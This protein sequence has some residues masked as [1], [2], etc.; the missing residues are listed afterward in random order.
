MITL[1]DISKKVGV[2][3]LFDNVNISFT[4][5]HRY[6]LTGPNGCG[7]STLLKILMKQE[8][9]TSGHVSMPKRVGYLRQDIEAFRGCRII[10]TVIMGNDRL[11]KAMEE[12]EELYSKEM[13][14]EIGMRLGDLEE[15]VAEEDGYTAESDAEILLEGMGIDPDFFEKPM[16]TIPLD[17]QFRVLL[18]QALFGAPEALLLDEPTNHLDL[19]AINW[20]EGFLKEYSGTLIVVSH[21]RHFLN[22]ITTHVADIDYETI[23]LYPGNYDEMVVAKSA[24]RERAAQDIKS[25]EKKISQLQEFIAKF[26]A[27]TRASQVQSR[28]RELDKLQ[29][30]ELAKS[31]IQR[32]YIRFVP[33]DKSPGQIIFKVKGICKTFEHEVIRKFSIEIMKGDKIAVIGP[34]GI[35][36]TTLLRML[37]GHLEPD[38][39]TI[40][41]GHE[42]HTGYFPQNHADLV[43]KTSSQSIFDYLRAQPVDVHD[44]EIRSVLGKMLFSGDDAFKEI[45]VLSGGETARLIMAELMLLQYNTLVM[46][47]PNGHLDLEAVSALGWALNEFKGTVICA[48]HDRDLINAFATKII[49][50]EKD[51]ITVF[52]GTLEEYLST[53]QPA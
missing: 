11:W 23:I 13:T 40:T 35:G 28:K 30:Q 44:Q 41:P 29:P 53:K 26:S 14:D 39:G 20:L 36:K 37:S 48:A 43:D 46:D 1:K 25:R 16:H 2:R 52:S 21:D 22:S 5:G 33:T 17:R 45:S 51:A 3:V 15:I 24:V 27:G 9:P 7:K 6:A 42:V 4:E 49:A 8:E 31:N 32:P 19:D 38:L 10:D 12:R 50:I 18:C 34:N 47:E